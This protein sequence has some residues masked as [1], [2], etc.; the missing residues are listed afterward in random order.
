MS[1]RAL[2]RLQRERDVELSSGSQCPEAKEDDDGGTSEAV[3]P[4]DTADSVHDR[5]SI[6]HKTSSG[7]TNLFDLVIA[8][9]VLEYVLALN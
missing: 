7:P 4:D 9:C 5:H 2:R 1:S 3:K 8:V 6:N